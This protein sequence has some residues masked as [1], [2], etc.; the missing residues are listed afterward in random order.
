MSRVIRFGVHACAHI[1]TELIDGYAE[2]LPK[3]CQTELTIRVDTSGSF[4]G[5]CIRV[6]HS[7]ACILALYM[8]F[9]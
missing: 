8:F 5:S 1:G 7:A 2:W 4:S 9:C 3:R 6:S